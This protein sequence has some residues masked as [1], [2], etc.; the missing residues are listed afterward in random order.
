MNIKFAAF[1]N[2]LEKENLVRRV[3]EDETDEEVKENEE[4]QRRLEKEGKN[5]QS[6]NGKTKEYQDQRHDDRLTDHQWRKSIKQQNDMSRKV[7]QL[8]D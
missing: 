1:K 6:E 7:Y 2:Y 4:D 3:E 8:M 5:P